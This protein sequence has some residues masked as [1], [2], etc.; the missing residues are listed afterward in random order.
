MPDSIDLSL[1]VHGIYSLPDAWKAKID[2]PAEA[3]YN[4]ECKL[5]SLVFKSGKVVAK[6]LT[7]EE[8][9]EAENNKGKKPPAKETGKNAKKVDEEPS[10]EELERQEA[11]RRER[12]ELNAKNKAEWDALTPN[13]Q[14]YRVSED[15]FK[16][17]SIRFVS[18]Q[19]NEEENAEPAN[20]VTD[21]LK[22]EALRCWES[23]V[24]DD[25]GI[26]FY[27][28]KAVPVEEEAE[29]KG[30]KAPAKGKAANTEEAKPTYGKAWLDLTQLMHPGSKS[31][32]LR[33]P[34]VTMVPEVKDPES[35][36]GTPNDAKR[37]DTTS[38]VE[39][40]PE[41]DVFEPNQT[42]VY[43]TI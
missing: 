1:E 30:K 4:Y 22:D 26:W 16:E 39:T 10:A 8:K 24:S 11:E 29:V 12:E 34:F 42:Y 43:I 35:L 17:P 2:D 41:T 32:S 25:R 38:A 27:F 6:E 7:E 14:F 37:P 33:A 23:S 40:I 21:K 31:V 28:T 13:E 15:P 20:I 19:T 18:E 3:A 9:L 36:K 5:N